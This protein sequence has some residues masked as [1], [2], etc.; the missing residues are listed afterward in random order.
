VEIGSLKKIAAPSAREICDLA[1][2]GGF[3]LAAPEAASPAE[4]LN[5][6]LAAKSLN[7]AVQFL[8]FAL[9][10]REAVWW[11]CQCSRAELPDPVPQVLQDA[12]DAAE[13]WVRKPTEEHRRAAMSRAQATDFQSPAAWAAVAAFWSSGSLAPEGLPEVPAPAHLMGCAVAGAVTLAAVKS[14]P[15]LA[16]QKRERYLA[17]AIDI[18]NGGTGRLEAGG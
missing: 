3:K 16:D 15:Q 14:E 9:P 8:A 5:D 11:A 10:A 1:K 13:T 12:V 6:L 18:A 7:E 4:F 2:V 17:S